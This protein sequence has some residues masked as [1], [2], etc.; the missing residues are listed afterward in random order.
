MMAGVGTIFTNDWQLQALPMAITLQGRPARLPI[1]FQ[2]G[3]G[4]LLGC[5][6]AVGS[7]GYA[8]WPPVDAALLIAFALV[9]GLAGA[10]LAVLFVVRLAY[11]R[12][13]KAG[14]GRFKTTVDA[15]LEAAA[16]GAW[17]PGPMM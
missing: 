10:V 3:L 15:L 5:A 9:F 7:V 6:V 4:W 1:A 8:L 13:A 16:E 11:Q 17:P 12:S 14:Q 2:R